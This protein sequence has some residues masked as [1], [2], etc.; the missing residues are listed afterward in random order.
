MKERVIVS[1]ELF[2]WL[3]QQTDLTSNQVDL[4]D[5]FVFMLQKMNKHGSIRL[6]GKRKV[7]PRFWRT[8]DKTF[9]YRL[10]GKKKKTQ[11]ALLYQF[12]VDV[13]FAE[14]LVFTE[15]ESI[16]LTDRGKIYLKMH[17]EDQLETLFQHIW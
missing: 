12:Y 11:I 14:G 5:G 10:M 15:D 3:N 7:H 16:Q 17:R 4:V 6:I 1:T 2:Q 13:A 9:G 8:H